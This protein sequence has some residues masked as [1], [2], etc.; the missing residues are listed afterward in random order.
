MSEQSIGPPSPPRFA[1]RRRCGAAEAKNLRFDLRP[2]SRKL[3]QVRDG[4]HRD[5]RHR[6]RR[7]LRKLGHLRDLDRRERARWGRW[8]RRR[9]RCRGRR[10]RGRAAGRWARGR[11]G[12]SARTRSARARRHRPIRSRGRRGSL[13]RADRLPAGPWRRLRGFVSLRT[14]RARPPAGRRCGATCRRR[15]AGGFAL[16]RRPRVLWVRGN[17]I[18][19]VGLVI[20]GEVRAREADPMEGGRDPDRGRCHAERKTRSSQLRTCG[21][22]SPGRVVDMLRHALIPASAIVVFLASTR[23]GCKCRMNQQIW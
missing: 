11:V 22:Q 13:A 3:R 19:A 7:N 17:G 18:G 20:Q 16:W 15:V 12:A 9:R 1:C 14:G 23:S 8:R 5:A 4:R 6:D 21:R 2:V 10:R